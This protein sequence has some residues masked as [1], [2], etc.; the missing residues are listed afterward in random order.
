MVYCLVLK[1]FFRSKYRA[2]LTSLRSILKHHSFVKS[3]NAVAVESKDQ[4]P[5]EKVWDI[6]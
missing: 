5:E 6:W 2:L 3:N 1:A 4:K